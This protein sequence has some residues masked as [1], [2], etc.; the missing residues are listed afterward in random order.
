MIYALNAPEPTRPGRFAYP[1]DGGSVANALF[2]YRE[3][4]RL[5]PVAEGTLRAWVSE[6]QISGHRRGRQKTFSHDDIQAAW[7]RR[8]PQLQEQTS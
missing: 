3:L 6:D 7:D 1:H 5:F 2:T 4:S 8:H